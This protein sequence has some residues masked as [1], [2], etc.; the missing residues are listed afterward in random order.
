MKTNQK[1]VLH[2]L[3]TGQTK[4]RTKVWALIGQFSGYRYN[5]LAA[6][7]EVM[8]NTHKS[9]LVHTRMSIVINFIYVMIE[10]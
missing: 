8:Q 10:I 9:I 2:I 6:T 1:Q 4:P 7:L 3:T 5:L